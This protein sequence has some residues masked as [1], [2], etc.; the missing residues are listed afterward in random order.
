MFQT[1]IKVRF[2]HVDFA[3]IVF[4]P[5]Y[6]EMFNEVVEKWCEDQLQCDFLRLHEQYN[7]GLPA[8][9]IEVDF[10]KPSRLGDILD[11]S[12]TVLK[13]GNSSISAEISCSCNGEQ[14][15]TAAITIV[16]IDKS[17][18]SDLTATG[19]PEVLRER[20]QIG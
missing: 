19:I 20:I 5:R 15:L 8:R 10:L 12:F 3:G 7:A 2:A 4:Y 17:Q 9:H 1:A 13:V 11:F 16:Y 14:R 6:F 18:D